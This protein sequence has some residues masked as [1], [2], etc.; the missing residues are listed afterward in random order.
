MTPLLAIRLAM[1]GG[2]LLFGGVSWFLHRTPDWTPADTVAVDSL[3]M[4]GRFMWIGVILGLAALWFRSRSSTSAAQ[5]STFA[6]IAW[7]LGETL[8]LFGG[9]LYFL[10]DVTGWYVAG[11][12]LLAITFVVFP[13]TL[14]A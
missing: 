14:Q 1:M 3:V 9:V 6:I 11:V 12:L 4:V 2:V 8:A 10:S 7:S 13:G 5:S